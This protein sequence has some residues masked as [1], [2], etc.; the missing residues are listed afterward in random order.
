MNAL[1]TDAVDATIIGGDQVGDAESNG[2]S[3][4]SAGDGAVDLHPGR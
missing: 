1:R 2:F 3:I 4:D